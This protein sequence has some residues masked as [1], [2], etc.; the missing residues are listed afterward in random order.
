MMFII[1]RN[2]ESTRATINHGEH[3]YHELVPENLQGEHNNIILLDIN[4]VHNAIY[5]ST[6]YTYFT[7]LYLLLL[8]FKTCLIYWP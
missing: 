6:E 8:F 3:E 2:L 1:S 7:S 5:R 4:N